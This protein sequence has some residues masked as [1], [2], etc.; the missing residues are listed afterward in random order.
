MVLHTLAVDPDMNGR[1]IG[2]KVIEFCVDKA[3]AEGSRALRVDIV[4]G[5]L[6]A[7]KL[8]EKNGFTYAGDADLERGFEDIPVFSLFETNW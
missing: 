8:Y 1:G 3:Q 7:R 6:P 5:N 2:S 4:P